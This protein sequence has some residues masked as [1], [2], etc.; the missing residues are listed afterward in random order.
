MAVLLGTACDSDGGPADP[1]PDPS[2][3][4]AVAV[5]LSEEA[6]VFSAAG[7]SQGLLA[8]VVDQNGQTMTGAAVEWSSSNPD[9]V[10]VDATG[11]V[12]AV[13]PGLAEITAA[14]GAA[15][16][17]ATAEVRQALVGTLETLVTGLEYPEG[18]WVG[19]GLVHL[20]ET[21]GRSTVFGGAERLLRYSIGS[22][23]LD[24]LLDA[25]ASAVAVGA[26]GTLYLAAWRQSVPGDQG[27]LTAIDPATLEEEFTLELGI[28]ATDLF[29]HREGDLYVAGASRTADAPSLT[30]LAGG[31]PGARTVLEEG[32]EIQAVTLGEAGL[33]FATAGDGEYRIL[34]RSGDGETT[35]VLDAQSLVT[36]LALD[37]DHLYFVM[38][39]EN[40]LA[41]IDLTDPSAVP[42]S[43]A[44]GLQEPATVRYDPAT[45][46]L[47]VLTSGTPGN[48]YRDGTLTVMREL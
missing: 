18:L 19:D 26:G 6:L 16:G 11:I 21:A 48:E 9:V 29:L 35:T 33:Y 27:S 36:S 5:E 17:T 43:V 45:A 15:S 1:R 10:D 2:T 20:T 23:A 39:L 40:A 3:P 28:A 31:D 7:E 46:S 42:Q 41:R 34:R 25:F 4:V 37:G 14:S 24:P 38:P 8:R 30:V 44:S 12:T 47:W 13:G 22:G 32:R